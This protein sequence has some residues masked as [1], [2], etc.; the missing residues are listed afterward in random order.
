MVAS[1][2]DDNMIPGQTY[3]FQFQLKNWITMP[4]TSTVQQDLFNNAPAFVS[5]DLQ[6]LIASTWNPFDNTYNIQFTYTGDGSD[7][8]SDVANAI[9]AAVSQ[10]SNDNFAFM[11]AFASPAGAVS[12]GGI[13]DS[14][15]NT[16]TD[17]LGKVTEQTKK[18][19]QDLLTPVEIAVGIVAIL[20]IAIIL[21]AGKSG[22]VSAGETGLNI[23]GR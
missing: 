7:V 10:G 12:P 19:A 14:V 8:I 20:V 23:G 15:T 16:V 5:S 6:V 13:L 2:L 1:Q 4:S 11:A 9:V 21:T 22:G 3:T 18:S 17:T